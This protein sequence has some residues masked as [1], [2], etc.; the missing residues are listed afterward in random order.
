MEQLE[1]RANS[2]SEA[3]KGYAKQLRAQGFIPAVMYGEGKE[4]IPLQVS[5]RDLF[6]ILS[7]EAKDHAIIQ[8][9]LDDGTERTVLLKEKQVHPVTGK[10]LHCDFYRITLDKAIKT[11]V[12]V[13]LIGNAAGVKAG[14]IM[15]QM[16]WEVEIESLPTK[17]P[18]HIEADVSSLQ[19]GD[20]LYLKDLKPI[21]GVALLGDPE[22]I[23]AVIAAPRE[24]EAE[25]VPEVEEKEPEVISERKKEEE[26]A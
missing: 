24:I 4:G 18:K 5:V 25:V 9:K 7:T 20:S 14:G 11:R 1:L 6:H 13:E 26:E 10:L 2:R 3:G 17:I 15:E 21:E 12:S 8:L 19:M 16:I 22:Q 23:I